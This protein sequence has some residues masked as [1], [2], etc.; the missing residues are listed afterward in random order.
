M[1]TL[2]S[3]PVKVVE[4]DAGDAGPGGYVEQSA[5]AGA[6]DSGVVLND[7]GVDQG[8][9]SSDDAG[10]VSPGL[11]LLEAAANVLRSS[12]GDC[13]LSGNPDDEQIRQLLDSTCSSSN[14]TCIAG[15]ECFSIAN[16][17][18]AIENS[19]RHDSPL[20]ISEDGVE[21]LYDYRDSL[22]Q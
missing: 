15:V 6:E 22:N 21:A 3:P 14:N 12:C 16:V 4:D 2:P 5:D 1:S 11:T 9:Q 19:D 10:V 18:C 20:S 17:L 13:H 7:S 8:V